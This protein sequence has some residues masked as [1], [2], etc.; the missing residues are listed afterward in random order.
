MDT[1]KMTRKA[2][3]D[4]CPRCPEDVRIGLDITTLDTA[5][6]V[7]HWQV[8]FL[9]CPGC[10]FESNILDRRYIG[11]KPYDHGHDHQPKG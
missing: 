5:D 9:Y 7:A 6:G 10:G 4:G 3:Q 8:S 1:L 2:E 11:A